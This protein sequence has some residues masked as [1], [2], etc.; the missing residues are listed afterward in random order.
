MDESSPRWHEVTRSEY[1]WEREALAR[2]REQLPDKAPWNAW[3]NFTFAAR[4]G[5][6]HEVDLLVAGPNGLFLI[7][8]KNYKGHLTDD[9]Q[10]WTHRAHT[11]TNPV[12]GA[13]RKSKALASYLATEA[14]RV[15]TRMDAPFV[16]ASVYLAEPSLRV[17]L[18]SYQR[19]RAYAP[20]D[21]VNRLPRLFE[22]L[23]LAPPERRAP[24]PRLLEKLPQLLARIGISA[25]AP[26]RTVGNW[27]LD[28]RPYDE[29]PTWQDF[30]AY[31][32]GV[33]G[34]PHRRVRIY[35]EHRQDDPEVR[36][37]VRRAAE[38]E[39]WAAEGVHH[40]GI[41]TPYD[42]V[43]HGL[44]PAL[45]IEQD[46]GASRLDEWLVRQVDLAMS[47]RVGLVRN[48]VSSVAYAHRKGLVHRALSPRAVIVE[49]G[50]PRVG[51]WQLSTRDMARSGS[52]R[53]MAATARAATHLDPTVE[54]YLA[55]EFTSE[56][57]DGRTDLDIFGVGAISYL[58]LT[59]RAPAASHAEL[60]DRLTADGGLDPATG[61]EAVDSAVRR[62]THPALSER[63][64][65]V[66]DLLE[67]LRPPRRVPGPET[68][69]VEKD[70]LEATEGEFLPG[71]YLVEQVLGTG[72]SARAFRV[73][74]DGLESVLKIGRG[75]EAEDVLAAEAAALEDLRHDHVVVLRRASFPVGPR[76]AIELSNAGERTAADLL[77]KEGPL[78]GE[79]LG[80]LG[81]Q[82]LAAVEYLDGRGV[83]HRDVKPANIGLQGG[84]LDVTGP[85]KAV[86][87]DFSLGG[88]PAE[89][90]SSGTPGYLDPHLGA[91]GRTVY[92]SS[93]EQY[94]VAATLHE[95]AT[96]ELPQWG[97]DGTAAAFVAEATL[98]E[99]AFDPDHRGA[100]RTFFRRALAKVAGDRFPSV[101]ALRAGWQS[102]F[103]EPRHTIQEPRPARIG[104]DVHVDVVTGLRRLSVEVR[105]ATFEALMSAC[106]PA[107]RFVAPEAARDERMRLLVVDSELSAV[108]LLPD[109]AERGL[110]LYL[111]SPAAT[112]DYARSRTA[113]VN[114]VSGELELRDA[115]AL[116]RLADALSGGGPHVDLFAH[117]TTADFAELGVDARIAEWARAVPTVEQLE[118][119][120]PILPAAQ[121]AVL[122]PLARGESVEAVRKLL[123][124][125]R[126]LGPVDTGKLGEA[127]GRSGGQVV[128][129]DDLAELRALLDKPMSQ[130]RTFL[131]RSQETLAYRP[132]WGSAQ[133]TGGPG[134]GKTVVALHRVKYLV[135][136]KNPGPGKVLLTTFT[137]G[138]AQALERDLRE[139]LGA[140]Q[141]AA[142]QVVNIDAWS[143]G[144][145][146]DRVGKRLSVLTDVK[147]RD[148]RWRRAAA[149]VGATKS[150]TF[151]HAEWEQVVLAQ[152]LT[153][154]D[155]Y[156]ECE[157]RG[158]GKPL[159]AAQRR[160]VWRAIEA[161]TTRLRADG[162]WTHPMVADEAARLLSTGEPPYDHVVVDEIQDLHPAHWRLVRSA[163]KSKPEDLF[164]TGDPHQR[165][166]GHRVS[167]RNVGINIGGRR[168]TKLTLSY[169]TSAEILAWS[170]R[171]LG[172]H[173][174]TGLDDV[175]DDLAAYRSAFS[176]TAPVVVGAETREQEMTDLA[177]ALQAGHADGIDWEDIAVVARGQHIWRPAVAVLRRAGVPAV[178]L[179]KSVAGDD[180]VRISTM[181]GLKGL[182]F[183]AVAVVGVSE[184]VIPRPGVIPAEEDAVVHRNEI[185]D[186]RNLLFVATTRPRE[187]LRVSWH[188]APSPFLPM[189]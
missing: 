20:D 57:V 174:E 179:N 180:A 154:E 186:E 115:V 32:P 42:L 11:E 122:L 30:H 118:N 112:A 178:E 136:Q 146:R 143:N 72:G 133:V 169:R 55:P 141:M 106:T 85:G 185:Q 34:N 33:A 120:Q 92:D 96:G 81:D 36:A 68:P 77:R 111:G 2:V 162:R 114:P 13:D 50:V 159:P 24:D 66:D 67:A 128:V 188:G 69:K 51:E 150:T 99:H 80:R 142:V 153:S 138:L 119:A 131:H 78:R 89:D 145:V 175:A 125:N 58:I 172:D 21:A 61:I 39:M 105:A 109:D 43:E 110:L 87:F 37:S 168:S 46:R 5:R 170:L 18:S 148:D 7:E 65:S 132:N 126:A 23:L 48:L 163:V 164:L 182:E 127:V 16:G 41:L 19:H 74:R 84:G 101:S 158:R 49:S 100:L 71:G 161:F 15:D 123:A 88:V 183:R 27:T 63:M 14:R 137:K 151:L 12:Y 60:R 70:P 140:E 53:Q 171:M 149:S 10:F 52:P 6:L 176:G 113:S 35:L 167:L 4:D 157:R 76:Y 103:D 139:M 181:H 155:D 86:L 98:A 8:V 45:L 117:V 95:L 62:A 97:D 104:L 130:F 9:G 107:P 91:A 90:T 177:A 29:G 147:E 26:S 73:R 166:Y 156:L 3:S 189:P 22:G 93:A 79:A 187:R 135:E 108:V 83:H 116:D 121:Y 47:A 124:P 75:A 56:G 144:L 165:I 28:S 82:V 31:R 134:T 173:H 94:S 129:L 40:P 54:P 1:P 25:A 102:A 38:R 152:R 160:T 44:G 64:P 184:G 59:G 17:D